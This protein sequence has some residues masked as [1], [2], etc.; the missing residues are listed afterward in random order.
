MLSMQV[1]VSVCDCLGPNQA[2]RSLLSRNVRN[3]TK[4]LVPI[5][6]AVDNRMGNM[7]SERAEFASERLADDTQAGLCGGERSK[8]RL[9][10]QRF[11]CTG[12]DDRTSV[13]Q[14]HA[15]N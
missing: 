3:Y 2:I 7:N 9:A 6:G 11:P 10:A 14:H 8:R 1:P 5:D 13:L 4:D 15:L 12:E